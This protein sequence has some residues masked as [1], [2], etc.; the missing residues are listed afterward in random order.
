MSTS[1]EPT[2]TP[3]APARTMRSAWL[4]VLIPKPTALGNGQWSIRAS[5]AA[6]RSETSSRAPV[7]PKRAW[8]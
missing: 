3:S 1:A 7:V 5:E 8:T 4:P 6:V 2:M